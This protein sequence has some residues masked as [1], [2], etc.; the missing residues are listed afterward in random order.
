[1]R[2]SDKWFD[3]LQAAHKLCLLLAIFYESLAA[4]LNLPYAE[5]VKTVATALAGL[6]VGIVEMSKSTYRQDQLNLINIADELEGEDYEE[7]SV[8]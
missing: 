2:L 3:R 8:G 1:M 5:E 6:I 4:G 7:E